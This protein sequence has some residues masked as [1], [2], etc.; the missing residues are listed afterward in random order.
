MSDTATATESQRTA[1]RLLD[2]DYDVDEIRVYLRDHDKNSQKV[3]TDTTS[4]VAGDDVTLYFDAPA[5]G[6][7]D[8]AVK[9]DLPGGDTRTL[10]QGSNALRVNDDWTS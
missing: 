2:L 8:V 4:Y 1:I 7:Y 6:G 3:A 9:A 5:P 10:Y